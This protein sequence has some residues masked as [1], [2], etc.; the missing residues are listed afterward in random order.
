MSE[1]STDFTLEEL[2]MECSEPGAIRDEDLLAYL[3][4]E[5]VRPAVVEHLARC[6]SCSS[7]L[8]AYNQIEL[9]LTSKLYRWDCPPNQVLGEYSLGMLS[10]EHAAAVRSHLNQCTLCTAEVA[11]LAN[12]LANDPV[13][14]ESAP[15]QQKSA[16]ARPSS[17]SN[18]RPVQEAKQV[19]EQLR[20]QA[21]VGT[22]RI[23][24][25]LLPAQPRLAYQRDAAP[26]TAQWP[27]RYAAEDVSIAVQVERGPNRRGALQLIG[28]VTR[29]GTTL[30]ALEGTPVQ[31]SAQSH[32]V[33]TQH[34]DEL[35]NFVFSSVAPATYTLE[36]QFAESV[37]V[38][39]QLTIT[40]Q[41]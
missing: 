17:L 28:F 9:K 5:T 23:V 16:S 6:Q 7:R 37:V 8:A 31:L 35:G 12:F 18:H 19:L 25:T 24:A 39:D 32:A 1:G 36:L 14:V 22:R 10:A 38:I 3:A 15:A 21:R 34:I 4:G 41:D 27:R 40:P 2:L 30:E 13:L 11:S 20:E 26:Q 33:Y 29:Q